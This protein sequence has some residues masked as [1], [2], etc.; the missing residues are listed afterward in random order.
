MSNAFRSVLF[1]PHVR[2]MQTRMGSREMYAAQDEE[3]ESPKEPRGP[4]LSPREA[5]FIEAQDGFY[6]ATVNETGWPYVQFRGGPTGFLKVLDANTVGYADFRGNVQYISVGNLQA[7]DRVSI[8]LMDYANQ[9][10]LKLIGRARLVDIS[11]D[12]ALR[13]RLQLPGY[14]AKVERA[15]VISLEGFDWNCPQHITPRYTEA[16]IEEATQPLR[17]RIAELEAQLA[18]QPSA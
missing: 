5:R 4:L 10:R 2:A 18:A 11:K 9:R 1:T 8:I 6:Q 17:A 16:E 15:V 7:D 12:E 3:Q 13:N 14:R